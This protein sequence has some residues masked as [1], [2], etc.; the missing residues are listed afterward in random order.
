MQSLTAEHQTLDH[1]VLQAVARVESAL[2]E[3]ASVNPSFMRTPEKAA[4]L[5]ELSRI[6]SQVAELRLRILADAEDVAAEFAGR[7][8]A[9]WLQWATRG[10][11]EDAR[12]DLR[13]AL[14]LDRRYPTLGSALRE[15]SA[16]LAQARVVAKV[17]DELPAEIPAEVIARAEEALVG[18]CAEFGP[19]QLDQI[20]RRIVDVVAPEVADEHEARALARLEERAHRAT[21]LSFHRVGDG[22]TRVTGLLPDLAATRLVTYL[23]AFTNPRR[24]S[25]STPDRRPYP[26]RLGK[27]FVRF[28]EAVDPQR[29]PI[30]GGEATTVVI[31]MTHEALTQEL[32]TAGVMGSD[33]KITAAQAR[34][35]ACTAHLVP[36]VLGTESQVLDLGRSTRLFTAGQRKAL[37]I[38]DRECRAEGCDI[39]G[40]WC[41]AHH[42]IPWSHGGR[43]DLKH[44]LLLCSHHHHR[45]HDPT[46]DADRLPN[47]DVRFSRRT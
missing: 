22:T 46:Y 16:N 37:L 10:R 9:G 30:H 47:G 20:G 19:R 24:A 8:V 17:L 34:R 7:D 23:E 26:R 31:T 42:W 12:A 13:L 39:P 35:L 4:A 6:E 28:L 5:A 43:T 41:E 1:P 3:V 44:G 40:T 25:A 45:A 32:A 27:A 14:A 36:A 15:G 11:G 38:R 18:H 2:A 33:E 29:L 21:R